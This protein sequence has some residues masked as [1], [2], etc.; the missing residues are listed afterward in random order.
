MPSSVLRSPL[1]SELPPQFDVIIVGAGA[2]GLYTALCL[3]DHLQIGLLTKDTLSLSAS[4][5]AQGGIA[6]VTDP[7]DSPALHLADTLQAGAGL[8]D[9]EAVKFLVEQAPECIQALVGMGVAFDRHE[10]TLALTLEAAHSRRRVLHAADTT[11]RE[12]VSTLTAQVLRRKNIH[13]LSQALTLDL[14]MDEAIDR[15]Q[16]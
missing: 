15:C 14:W 16:G 6:A 7:A 1:A 8:C 13:V 5:W 12:V 4:D 2:A 3:P 9:Y 11:G 10:G